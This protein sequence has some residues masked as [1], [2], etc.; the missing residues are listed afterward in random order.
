MVENSETDNAQT[1]N[2]QTKTISAKLFR[3]LGFLFVTYVII[4]LVFYF[5]QSWMMFPGLLRMQVAI[6]DSAPELE[7][8]RIITPDKESLEGI[9]YEPPNPRGLVIVCHG[10]GDLVCLMQGEVK[11]LSRRF[12]VAVLA[13]D[14]R[15]YGNSDGFP[16]DK[17]LYGDGQAVYDFAI[18][19]GYTK[20][21][22]VIYG[23]S[24]GGAIAVSM[25]ENN[26]IAG[27]GIRSSFSKMSDLAAFKYPWLPVR[28]LIR[29]DFPSSEKFSSYSGPLVQMH[30]SADGVIPIK[31]GRELFE[32]ATNAAPKKFMEI[33]GLG[34]N[35]QTPEPFWFEFGNMLDDCL[36]ERSSIAE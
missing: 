4:L 26:P 35:G 2:T 13:F 11:Y 16:T 1:A 28:L 14:Y 30:G 21:N 20:D 27:L 8:V 36:P 22:I 17:R 34:H 29:N 24:L 6:D 23:R 15:G 7:V 3:W 32:S 33:E 5:C 12:N 25:A 10:N 19:Q 18:G 31:F 9:L